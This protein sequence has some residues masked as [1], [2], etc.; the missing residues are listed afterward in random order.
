[1][2]HQ[3]HEIW[4]IAVDDPVVWASVC[5][6]LVILLIAPLQYGLYYS[7]LA[8][9]RC[10]LTAEKNMNFPIKPSFSAITLP[11]YLVKLSRWGL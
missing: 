11:Y 2:S 5:L 1:M 10:S 4:T 9:R 6:F 8:I 7:T 3:M